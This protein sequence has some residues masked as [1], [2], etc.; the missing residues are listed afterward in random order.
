VRKHFPDGAD[1][2]A[3]TD[4]KPDA[5]ANADANPD[6]DANTYP[7]ADADTHAVTRRTECVDERQPEP[8]AEDGRRHRWL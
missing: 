4:P 6:A 3:D 2:D 1:S 7:D 5:D 8:G